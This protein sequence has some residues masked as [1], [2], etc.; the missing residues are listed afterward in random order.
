MAKLNRPLSFSS[1]S[2]YLECPQKY[3]FKYID[4]LTEKPKHFFSF[5]NSIHQSLEYFCTTPPPLLTLD[6]ILEYYQKNWISAGYK[7]KVQENGYFND[8]KKILT[9]F[10]TK[11][12]LN[13]SAPFSIEYSFNINIEGVPVTGKVD[14]IDK[15]PD[16]KLSIIDYKT[17]KALS[18]NRVLTDNQLTMYQIACEETLGAEV[19]RLI[20]HHLPTSAEQVTG[21]RS[22]EQVADFKRQIVDV[23]QSIVAEKFEPSPD[24][25]KCFWCDFKK[26]CPVFNQ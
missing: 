15:L 3:K 16:G 6:Q 1:I 19:S 25:R 26:V 2:M 20:F 22:P 21:R 12:C 23:A 18:P 5:G 7:D 11:Y 24:E 10:H 8:G 17:G 4:K 9:L 13:Y 14:R